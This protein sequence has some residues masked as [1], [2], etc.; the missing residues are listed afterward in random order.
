MR[1]PKGVV[2][3]V[4]LLNSFITP[5]ITAAIN[6]A[7]P[8]IGKEF[9]LDAVTLSW[10]ATSY[11]LT[12]AVLLLPFGRLGDLIG[13]RIIFITGTLIFTLTSLLHV[14][15]GSIPLLFFARVP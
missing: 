10:L 7:L 15:T 14:L 8:P 5:F 11:L 3:T 6:I 2:L 9:N 1:S 4:V 12:V 13:R